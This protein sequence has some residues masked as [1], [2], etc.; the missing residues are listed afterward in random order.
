[1]RPLQTDLSIFKK[2]DLERP[3]LGIKFLFFKPE[4]MEPLPPRK[5][6]L[7]VRDDCGSSKIQNALLL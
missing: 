7:P 6:P 3:P 5:V 4:G 1:M 2:L